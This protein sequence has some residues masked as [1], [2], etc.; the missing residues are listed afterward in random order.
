M[1]I[2]E[3][4]LK[5]LIQ[6]MHRIAHIRGFSDALLMPLEWRPAGGMTLL[7][8][9]A[10]G[11]AVLAPGTHRTT[12]NDFINAFGGYIDEESNLKYSVV[13]Q[14]ALQRLGR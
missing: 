5:Y 10:N 11:G 6:D 14:H 1:T 13:A 8:E 7:H 2:Y 9:Y 3:N 12:M 4:Q